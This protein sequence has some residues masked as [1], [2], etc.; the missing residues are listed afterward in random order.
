M[1]QEVTSLD[2]TAVVN[3]ASASNP[4]HTLVHGDG[5]GSLDKN[6]LVPHSIGLNHELD[7]IASSSSLIYSQLASISIPAH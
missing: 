4:S 2:Y 5:K 3:Q 7:K 1:E 6:E